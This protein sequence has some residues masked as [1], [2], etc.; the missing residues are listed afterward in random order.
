MAIIT[1]I[2]ENKPS[3]VALTRHS[4]PLCSYAWYE[5][6]DADDYPRYCPGCGKPYSLWDDEVYKE[7]E[8]AERKAA[9][10]ELNTPKRPA[11]PSVGILSA[12]G[13]TSNAPLCPSCGNEVTKDNNRCPRCGQR[14]AWDKDWRWNGA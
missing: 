12:Y 2:E 5:L 6:T 14:L 13:M 3:P 11:M 4:C 7:T 8:A 10:R 9:E 1:R